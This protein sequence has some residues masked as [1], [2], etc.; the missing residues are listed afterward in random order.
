LGQSALDE[1]VGSE[2]FSAVTFLL[3]NR[4]NVNFV[5]VIGPLKQTPLDIAFANRGN[6]QY[7][8]RNMKNPPTKLDSVSIKHWKI[9]LQI[10]E[11]LLE[12]GASIERRSDSGYSY[13]HEAAAECDTSVVK[14]LLQYG[15]DKNAKNDAGERPY[16][17]AVKNGCKELEVILK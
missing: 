13:L 4:A 6:L 11:S 9:N 12:A 8:L 16:D 3:R 1:A 5:S 2:S 17:V 7:Q 15:A 10:M 14:L